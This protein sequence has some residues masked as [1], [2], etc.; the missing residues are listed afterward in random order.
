MN[1]FFIN[2]LLTKS[3]MNNNNNNK[4]TYKCFYKILSFEK[5]I[6]TKLLCLQKII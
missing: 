2:I 4:M 5:K 6:A 1:Q 3:R